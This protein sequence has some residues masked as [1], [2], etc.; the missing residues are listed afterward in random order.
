[1][2][3]TTHNRTFKE[4]DKYHTMICIENVEAISIVIDPNGEYGFVYQG[5]NPRRHNAFIGHTEQ[6]AYDYTML[7]IRRQLEEDIQNANAV[8]ESISSVEL[9]EILKIWCKKMQTVFKTAKNT[10]KNIKFES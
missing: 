9:N 1:M 7:I 6:D 2:W 4:I 3:Q 10:Y 8:G 5:K